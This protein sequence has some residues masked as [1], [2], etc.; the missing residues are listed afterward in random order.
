MTQFNSSFPVIHSVLDPTALLHEMTT[1]Y[2]LGSPI[3]ATLLRSWMNEVYAL[4]TSRGH[5]ILKVFRH[6]WRSPEELAYEIS[7]MQ[8]LAAHDV[9]VAL[10]IR[11]YDGTFVGLLPAPEGSRS[12]VLYS[13][14]VGRPPVPPDEAIYTQV[15]H[16]IAQMHRALDSFTS[17]HTRPAL[18]VSYLAEAPLRWLQPHLHARPADWAFLEMLVQRVQAHL[19][20]LQHKGGLTW[21]PIHADATL[22]NLLI[23]DNEQ[24]GIYDFDQSGPGW[25][26]YELQ[27][28]FHYAWLIKRPSFWRQWLMGISRCSHSAQLILRRCHALWC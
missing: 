25:R 16:V 17:E 2:D 11:R 13:G 5:F 19:T 1:Q 22:D 6:G 8:H 9:V 14:L 27:G 15:G 4:H 23:T 26:G 3:S 20:H 18:D 12:V 10:P 28:V 24:M 21:G 7:L